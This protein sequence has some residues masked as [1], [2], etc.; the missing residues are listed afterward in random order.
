MGD[1]TVLRL[2]G[3]TIDEI[4]CLT[5]PLNLQIK[6]FIDGP[7]ASLVGETFHQDVVLQ[8][9]QPDPDDPFVQH[10]LCLMA[11]HRQTMQLRDE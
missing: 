2:E 1:A 6:S 8:S 4:A 7:Y 5:D 3:A 9:A 10:I 11:W